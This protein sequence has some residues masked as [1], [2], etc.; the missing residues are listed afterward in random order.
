[1]EGAEYR[2]AEDDAEGN[3]TEGGVDSAAVGDEKR[4]RLVENLLKG[5]NQSKLFQ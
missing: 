2:G 3:V 1:M 5:P 4:R